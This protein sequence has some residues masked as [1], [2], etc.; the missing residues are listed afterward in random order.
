MQ[1]YISRLPQAN[2]SHS[3]KPNISFT[4][5][6]SSYIAES[7]LQGFC[8]GLMGLELGAIITGG[9]TGEFF[10]GTKEIGIVAEAA[11]ISNF[12]QGNVLKEFFPGE[13]DT[14]VNDVVIDAVMD[15]MHEFVRKGRDT[16]TEKL[17]ESIK[18]QRLCKMLIDINQHLMHQR[19]F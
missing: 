17:G 18:G 3:A 7:Q 2:I 19:I 11:E 15:I 10:E 1:L 12:A 5:I 16:D 8:F 14:A 4:S 6:I 13:H 9:N